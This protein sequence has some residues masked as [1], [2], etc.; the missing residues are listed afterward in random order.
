VK[1]PNLNLKQGVSYLEREEGRERE[2]DREKER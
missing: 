2:R 1:S